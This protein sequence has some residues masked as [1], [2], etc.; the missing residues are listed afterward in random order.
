M[1]LAQENRRVNSELYT[2]MARFRIHSR[3]I[4]D[5]TETAAEVFAH[6]RL[7]V[8]RCEICHETHEFEYLAC[9]HRFDVLPHGD[10]PPL[11]GLVA[12]VGARRVVHGVFLNTL[13]ESS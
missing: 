12:V 3:I 8:I 1:G 13:D 2:R 5:Q 6:L 9:S 7:V 11:V 4:Q 10:R